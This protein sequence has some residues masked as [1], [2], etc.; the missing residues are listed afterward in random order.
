MTQEEQTRPKGLGESFSA[1]NF[2]GAVEFFVVF[3]S[4]R[5]NSGE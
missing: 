5:Q 3:L 2:T 4:Q 1:E